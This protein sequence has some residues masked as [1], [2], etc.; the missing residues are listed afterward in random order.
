MRTKLAAA[1]VLSLLSLVPA[2]P[3]AAETSSRAAPSVA[4]TTASLKWG[5]SIIPANH[6]AIGNAL[7]N[8]LDGTSAG[9]ALVANG[10]DN[11]DTS[12][13]S[14]TYDF[15]FF[16]FTD[17]ALSATITFK[18]VSPSGGDVYHYSWSSFKLGTGPNWFLVYPKE[19]FST[20]G[21]YW[22]E[23]YGN[24]MGKNTLLTWIP[25]LVSPP[26]GG[27]HHTAPVGGQAGTLLHSGV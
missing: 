4:T 21:T 2:S 10:I 5:A 24:A 18:I 9:D 20:A 6:V 25:V 17:E 14:C 26:S 1:A 3:T 8:G 7:P 16:V 19:D 12:C 13:T 22:A 15:A 23:V 11:W 27:N